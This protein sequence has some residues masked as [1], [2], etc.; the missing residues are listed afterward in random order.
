M[1]TNETIANDDDLLYPKDG[2]N[3]DLTIVLLISP[4]P[5]AESVISYLN[6]CESSFT[7]PILGP[8][9]RS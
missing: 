9:F 7:N 6:D 2:S 3:R 4:N 8:K 5:Y 1:K